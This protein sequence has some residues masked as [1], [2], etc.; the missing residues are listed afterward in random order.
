MLPDNGLRQISVAPG[1]L[2]YL[3]VI[4]T[5]FAC[6]DKL[7][8]SE[9]LLSQASIQSSLAGRSPQSEKAQKWT[10][11]DAVQGLSCFYDDVKSKVRYFLRIEFWFN[12]RHRKWLVVQRVKD[13]KEGLSNREAHLACWFSVVA[14]AISFMQQGPAS[15]SLVMPLK[16][17]KLTRSRKFMFAHVP[18][19]N[20][21]IRCKISSTRWNHTE[22]SW[23]F[24]TIVYPSS[25]LP[26]NYI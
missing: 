14:V 26:H 7:M 8:E 25:F 11:T 6:W 21:Q 19:R 24:L 23:S 1:I 16:S 3:S 22:S 18:S 12:F 10:R 4:F 20:F 17:G 9:I 15:Y 5:S 2:L 13:A